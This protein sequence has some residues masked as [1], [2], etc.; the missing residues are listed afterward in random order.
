MS[1]YEGGRIWLAGLLLLIGQAAHAQSCSAAVTGINFGNVNPISGAA[2]TASGSIDVTCTWPVISLT[3]SV[4]VCLNLAAVAPLSMTNGSNALRYGLY[5]DSADSVVWGSTTN[6]TTPISLTLTKPVVGT[7]AS[8]VVSF[9]GLI[10]ANQPTV[11][12]VGDISTVYSENLGGGQTVLNY[13]FYLLPPSGCPVITTPGATFP[14]TATATVVNDCLISAN[15]LSFGAAGLLSSGISASAS[16]SAT[17]TNSDAYRIALNGGG[18]GNVAARTMSRQGGGGVVSY[19]LYVDAAHSIPWGD[20][21]AGTSMYTGTGTGLAQTVTVY[22][23]VSA[24]AT[25]APGNYSDTITATIA[26]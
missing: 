15:N 14:F 6:G 19:Q 4:E 5:Q 12:T 20:G 13:E 10:A 17:C 23:H 25:P 21:T 24:Q 8:Q 18:S 16:I 2:V 1:L 9:Y 11:P 26:F 3:P 7:S 22:G